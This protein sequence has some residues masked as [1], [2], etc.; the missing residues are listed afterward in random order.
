MISADEIIELIKCGKKQNK[1]Y[2]LICRQYNELR[3]QGMDSKEAKE[4]MDNLIY[5][6]Y[7]KGIDK[8]TIS[9][10]MHLSQSMIENRLNKTKRLNLKIEKE[11]NDNKILEGLKEGK[12]QTEIAKELELTIGTV[13]NRIRKMKERGVE[14]PIVSDVIDNK[15]LKGLKEGKRKQKL[16]KN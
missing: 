3:E 1:I 14:I 15:I 8:K 12:K 16:Q 5:K 4:L 10:I 7:I 2:E 13:S 9:G 6:L 11:E